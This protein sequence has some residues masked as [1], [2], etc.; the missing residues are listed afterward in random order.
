MIWDRELERRM[1]DGTMNPFADLD[2]GQAITG[3][4][5]QAAKVD[6]TE[7]M[8]QRTVGW[9]LARW[10]KFTGSRI[11]DLMKQGRGK[12]EL[13]GENAKNIILELAAFHTMTKEGREMYAIEQMY[14]E[15]RQ[16]KWGNTYEP[17]ARDLY[18]KKTGFDVRETGFMTH[19]NYDYIGG[20]FDGEV[21]SS[22]SGN[23]YADGI[24]EIKCPYDPLKHLKN[25]NLSRTGID[26]KH[27]YYG[28]IQNNIEVAGVD[29]CDFVSYDPRQDDA[30]KIVIIRVDR[31]QI[32]IDAMMERIHKAEH[33]LN[34]YLAGKSLEES[35]TEIEVL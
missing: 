9:Y 16:T 11:P 31:D 21:Y 3:E 25:M 6:E 8:K 27:E 13:W 15:F 7:Q 2:Q 28:Q 23:P 34:M 17:E 30:H 35:I 14:K 20:S 24:I 10:D 22:G 29:W 4:S 33:I 12:N 26:A 18:A 5:K 32:Y 19:P 1:E